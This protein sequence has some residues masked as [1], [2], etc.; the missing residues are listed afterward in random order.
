M[1]SMDTGQSNRGSQ[2]SNSMWNGNRLGRQ[3]ENIKPDVGH[4]PREQVSKNLKGLLGDAVKLVDLQMQLL[5]VDI[6]DFWS[7]AKAGLALVII[8]SLTLFCG[9]I[10]LFLG[11]SAF[12]ES[13]LDWSRHAAYFTVGGVSIAQAAGLL[14]WAAKRIGYSAGKLSRSKEELSDNLIWFRETFTSDD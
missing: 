5:A 8:A 9:L 7:H 11:L 1:E 2:R 12:L 4:A 14:Y 13:Q 10:V 3:E 6:Q